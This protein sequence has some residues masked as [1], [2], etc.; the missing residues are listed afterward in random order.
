VSG[1][2]LPTHGRFDYSPITHRPDYFWP[3]RKRLALWVALNVET[4]GF[5]MDGPVLGNPLPKPDHRNWS[6]REYGNRVG[7]WRLLELADQF[8]IPL[9][10]QVNSYL[11][12]T[13]PEIMAALS[14]RRRDEILGHGRTNSEAPGQR[15]EAEEWALIHEAT[16]AITRNEGHPP[17]GW[18]TPLQAESM[19]TPDLLKAAGYKYIV[20]W[21][22]DDQPYWMRTHHGPL[23]NV[24]YAVETNDY[25][26]VIHLRQDAPVYGEIVLRQFEEMVEQSAERPLVMAISLHT[27]IMGQPHRVRVL[28]EIFRRI[29]SHRYFDRVWLTRPGDIADHCISLQPGL[30]P[31]S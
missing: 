18:M 8:E 28:R 21:P 15:P 13:H 16:A 11:Y 14:R 17:A 24:P 10:H 9:A 22:C 26:S 27:F 19:V 6:W 20:D 3:G 30:V 12:D 4:F 29:R 7:I 25:L 5:G 2:P 1:G 31:G 23:L